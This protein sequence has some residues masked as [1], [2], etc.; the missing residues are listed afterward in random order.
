MDAVAVPTREKGGKRWMVWAGRVVSLW[1]AFVIITSA[2]WKLTR[3]PTYV[4]EFAR[5]G[6]PESALTGLALLQLSCLTLYL[7]PPTAILGAVLL[8]GYLGGAIAA[9]VRLGEPYP[10]L[11]PLST[12]LIAWAGIYMRDERLRRLLPL[13]SLTPA[14]RP[15]AL[16]SR[17][18]GGV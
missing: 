1:P 10:V 15:P 5:I 9:Y 16:R 14:A 17:G 12:S 18:S 11:V 4:A 3:A 8:T 7:I 6:W 13:R 2:T